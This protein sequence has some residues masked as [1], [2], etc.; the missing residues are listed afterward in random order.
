MIF[1]MTLSYQVM[2]PLML[3][4]VLAYYT[5][6]QSEGAVMYE[7]TVS[8]IREEKVRSQL[9]ATQMRELVQPAE[10]VLPL[11]A[12]FQDI[13][14]MFL[15]FPVKYIYIVDVANRYQG[16]VALQDLT[17]VLLQHQDITG[18]T[19]RDFLRRDYLKVIT[20]DMS[21][22]EALACFIMHQGERLPAIQ[23]TTD[24]QLLGVVHKTALLDAYHRL[25]R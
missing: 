7:I 1:E 16:V 13:A 22:D 8:R 18:K 10:T 2:L 11:D 25:N 23:S 14:G 6:R 17:S 15:Q 24:P 9:R 12:P 3:A 4:C 21:L 5:A 19:A 20:P